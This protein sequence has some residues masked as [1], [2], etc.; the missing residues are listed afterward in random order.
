MFGSIFLDFIQYYH[1]QKRH[2]IQLNYFQKNLTNFYFD[3]QI[4]MNFNKNL[5]KNCCLL[6]FFGVFILGP[7]QY[8]IE[9]Y[10]N[11]QLRKSGPT[12]Q[13]SAYYGVR[14][15][16]ATATTISNG[17]AFKLFTLQ[18][19]ASSGDMTLA[20]NATPTSWSYKGLER[21]LNTTILAAGHNDSVGANSALGFILS[22]S[23]GTISG[24]V[25][26][27]GLAD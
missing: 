16:G 22:A 12:T 13:A 2:P 5:F 6:D 15:T 1:F 26:V 19:E 27:Y 23:S 3:L 10:F 25:A 7:V 11:F 18:T 17:T 24:F 4:F 20:R 21:Y 9:N 8:S 14:L